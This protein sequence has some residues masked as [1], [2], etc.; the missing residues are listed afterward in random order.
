MWIIST[1]LLPQLTYRIIRFLFFAKLTRQN[2]LRNIS[3]NML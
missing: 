1:C 3:K 2:I